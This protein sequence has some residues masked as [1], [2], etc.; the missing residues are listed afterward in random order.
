MG[1]ITDI[2]N[3]SSFSIR[4]TINGEKDYGV[5]E[6]EIA[7]IKESDNMSKRDVLKEINELELKINQLQEKIKRRGY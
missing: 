1:V 2:K 3:G 5:K 4:L 6:E 7:L